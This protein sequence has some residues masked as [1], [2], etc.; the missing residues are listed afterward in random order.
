MGSGCCKAKTIDASLDVVQT[1]TVSLTLKQLKDALDKQD[2]VK[3]LLVVSELE[4]KGNHWSRDGVFCHISIL[5]GVLTKIDTYTCPRLSIHSYHRSSEKTAVRYADTQFSNKKKFYGKLGPLAA[6][7]EEH[8]S[9][10]ETAFVIPVEDVIHIYYTTDVKKSAKAEPHLRL[11]PVVE[12]KGCC[13][14]CCKKKLRK[15]YAKLKS[16]KRRMQNGLLQYIFSIQSTTNWIQYQM[17]VYFLHRIFRIRSMIPLIL[18][19]K[20]Q[21]DYLC[22]I[23]MQLKGINSANAISYPSPQELLQILNQS[24]YGIFGD[25][26]QER[27]HSIQAQQAFRTHVPAPTTTRIT[28]EI[29]MRPAN[30]FQEGRKINY[31]IIQ[32][33]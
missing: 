26:Y 31:N 21:A 25:L 1:Q 20:K 32:Y 5:L 19:R 33:Y 17:H 16:L 18:M 3:T 12:K 28:A 7:Q 27:L 11:V 2:S 6:S 24:Y 23:I 15:Q 9:S 30:K 10:D 22:R 8:L 29:A 14:R 4:P 13:G